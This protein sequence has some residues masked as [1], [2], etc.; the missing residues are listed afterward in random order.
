MNLREKENQ[1]LLHTYKRLPIEV[2]HADGVYVYGKDGKK[3]L[4][5][6]GGIAVNALGYNNSRV[7]AAIV[8]QA[9]R[10]LHMSNTFYMDVQIELA[11]TLC[12]LSGYPKMFLTNSGTEAVE[13]AIKISR[14]WGKKHGK[15]NLFALTNSFHGRT[16]GSL[17]LTDREKYRQDFDPFLPSVDHIAFNNLNDLKTKVDAATAAVFIEF[18]QGEGGINVVSSEF[19]EE[20]Y[21][22]K[23]KYNF[24]V[25]ADEI[26]SGIY[27]TGKLFAFEHFGVRPDI[28]TVAKPIGGGLP[29]GGI[30]VD[31]SA[32]D[33]LGYGTHGTTFGG[34]PLS[35][36]A[37]L[38]TLAELTEKKFDEHVT[39]IG[40]YLKRNLIEFKESHP[41]FVA[42]VRG[43]GLMLGVECRKECG[44]TVSAL[45]TNG[46]IANC[47][48][49]NVIRLL[50]PLVVEKEHVD[51]FMSR[52]SET[53]SEATK[54]SVK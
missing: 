19:I 37:G 51:I 49:G 39:K 11:E 52:L 3:Y 20:L 22:L 45:L 16:M 18:I 27:R 40:G 46:V 6:F 25:V 10:Y 12:K 30:L 24:L 21:N 36:A 53:V 29:L 44:E 14:K 47:T 17:S 5:F 38:A 7:K 4:D 41:D 26:Q 23:K 8:N 1:F 34:N 35:C 28:V 13:A 31:S 54:I 2:D 33:V 50:P 43:I 32:E 48:S 15:A 9:N 42:E